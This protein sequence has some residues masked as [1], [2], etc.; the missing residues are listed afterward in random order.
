MPRLAV[1]ALTRAITANAMA[2]GIKL[3]V[4]ISL[5][6]FTDNKAGHAIIIFG[7]I[8]T[9]DL[10]PCVHI[11]QA[12]ERIANHSEV[13]VACTCIVDVDY[14]HHLFDVGRNHRQVHHNLFVVTI[15]ST[16]KIITL[17]NNSPT[18]MPQIAKIHTALLDVRADNLAICSAKNDGCITV[19]R[20]RLTETKE[21][22]T[23]A[24]SFIPA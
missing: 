8:K 4:A 1:R 2:N 7:Q 19:N 21:S 20:L 9:A 3:P 5:I 12:N 15:S 10:S 22:A 18:V 13:L 16:R 6:D 17:M 14:E 23:T 11:Y 24:R